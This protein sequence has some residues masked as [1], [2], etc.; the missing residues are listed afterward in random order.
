MKRVFLSCL[1]L[2]G[3]QAYAQQQPDNRVLFSVNGDVVTA[4]E[5][6]TVYNKNNYSQKA[7]TVTDLEEYLDLY[8]KFKLKVQE[9]YANGLDTT[10]KFIRELANYR[11]QLAQ[12]YLR[13]KE[14]NAALLQ[15]AYERTTI[16]RRAS[17]IM[18]RIEENAPAAD[19]LAAYQKALKIR[20]RLIRGEDFA[21]LATELSEDPSAK[22]NGGDLGFFSAFRMIY[23]F[24]DMAYK[25]KIGEISPVFRTQ[26]GYHILKATDERP[27]RGEIRVAHLMLVLKNT[28]TD[29]LRNNAERRARELYKKIQA[30]ESFEQLVTQYSEDPSSASNQGLLP[31][32]GTGRMVP[33]FEEAAFA[34]NKDGDISEPILTPY[35]WHII[36]RIDYRPVPTF[37]LAKGDLEARIARDLRASINKSRLLEKLK[38]EYKFTENL[39]ARN[40]VFAGINEQAYRDNSWELPVFDKK[41]EWVFSFADKRF[42]QSDFAAYLKS[43]Q[44][45]IMAADF[46]IF[47]NN[48]YGKW[49]E[50]ELLKYE[51]SR[52]E[53]KY[54]DF[55]LLMKEYREGIL[56]FDLTDQM[57]WSKAVTD[58][59]G[60]QAFFEAND[61]NYM[62]KERIEADIFTAMDEKTAK[63]VRKAAGKKKNTNEKLLDATNKQNLL[64]LKI[65]SGK[66]EKGSQEALDKV[67]W[68]PGMSPI[69]EHNG[70]FVF[71]KVR[72]LLPPSV[73]PL[74]E[75]RGLVTSDYQQYLEREWIKELE[76]KYKVVINQETFN[77]LLPK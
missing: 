54:D 32:F 17:H 9:A 24:E 66:F 62:Y 39:K 4:Q 27:A 69:V 47:L 49:L 75:I 59:A 21:K 13:D 71:V 1:M 38:K 40:Q 34:L 65:K 3:L 67:T 31:Y 29:S 5:F 50:D 74:N 52:L 19:S 23:P 57:V 15:E 72:E 10:T 25:S 46:N 6:M 44:G 63:T 77:S 2:I 68:V 58:S 35:G 36:K 73:K 45:I 41:D 14:T 20:E 61:A 18:V 70:Q 76:S 8:V 60:L 37:E 51:D 11:S 55:R 7:P 64:A 33:E 30:G 16:E 26:F 48:A 53:E 43:Q 56:L 42:F 22:D 28:D 12:P